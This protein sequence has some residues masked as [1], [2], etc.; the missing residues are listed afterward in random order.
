MRVTHE[1]DR[2]LGRTVS[3]FAL[4]IVDVA[5]GENLGAGLRVVV[6][7][8]PEQLAAG[9]TRPRSLRTQER[10][11]ERDQRVAEREAKEAER[12]RTREAEKEEARRRQDAADDSAAIALRAKSTP[13]TSNRALQADLQKVL[14]C[15][16]TRAWDALTRTRPRPA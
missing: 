4:Q 9:N 12:K 8:E 2:E 7:L 6:H 11:E 1:K 15:G 3:D 13:G 5:V 16:G 14:A 10:E